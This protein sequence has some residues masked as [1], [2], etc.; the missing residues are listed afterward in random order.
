MVESKKAR[1]VG[2]IAVKRRHAEAET[3]SISPHQKQV[4]K[5]ISFRTKRSCEVSN[6]F[7]IHMRLRR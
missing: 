2:G 4:T 3:G 6:A 7:G 5:S 1:K